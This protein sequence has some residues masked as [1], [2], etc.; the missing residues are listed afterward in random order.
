MPLIPWEELFTMRS[1]SDTGPDT[2]RYFPYT[3]H[4]ST[5]EDNPIGDPVSE[6]TGLIEP[7]EDD[8]Q[9]NSALYAHTF[10]L[11]KGEYVIGSSKKLANNQ[12]AKIYYLA[13]QGQ[14]DSNLG[15]VTEAYLDTGVEN[16][17]FLLADPLPNPAPASPLPYTKGQTTAGGVALAKAEFSF[18]GDFNT[19]AGG[20]QIKKKDD[21]PC[22]QIL[23]NE[24]FTPSNSCTTALLT[25]C[26]KAS[27]RYYLNDQEYTKMSQTWPAVVSP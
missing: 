23:F 4:A 26:R 3:L 12:K 9:A 15:R 22:V 19:S 21:A 13:V 10:K 2:A 1:R 25:Y 8:M 6:G 16:V 20:I 17:D 27:P 18:A 7:Q 11:E 24:G 5:T 14:D